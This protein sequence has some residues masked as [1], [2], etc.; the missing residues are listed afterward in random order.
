MNQNTNHDEHQEIDGPL[1][2]AVWAVVGEKI[3]ADA[4]ER[5]K[6]R[7]KEVTLGSRHGNNRDRSHRSFQPFLRPALAAAVVAVIVAAVILMSNPFGGSVVYAKAAE[8]LKNLESMVCKVQFSE[9]GLLDDEYEVFGEQQVTYLAPSLHRI[10]DRRHGTV[11]I[12]DRKLNRSVFLMSDAKQAIV[13]EGL[14]ATT[15]DA[16]SP[17]R[18]VEVLM[19]HVHVDRANN[20]DV[21]SIGTRTVDGAALRGYESIIDGETVRVWFDTETLLP[22]MIAVRLQIPSQMAGGNSVSIWQIMSDIKVDVDVSRDLFVTTVPGGYQTLSVDGNSTDRSPSTLN[23][24]VDMLRLCAGA[25]KSE[26]PAW[27]SMNDDSGTPL[28]IQDKFATALEQQVNEGSEQEK[29]SAIQSLQQFGATVGRA[30]AFQFSMKPENDWHYFGGAKL[31]DTSRPVLWYSPTADDKYKVIYADLSVKDVTRDNLPKQPEALA[32]QTFP[33][34]VIRVST[35]RFTLPKGTIRDYAEL[36]EIRK[37]GRQS[38]VTYLSLAWMPELME[39][40]V[41]H[42][43]GDE[44]KM[45]EV[46]PDWKPDRSSSGSRLAFL[47]EFTNLKGLDLMGLYLTQGD[48]D[49]IGSCQKL[50]R[51]SLYGVYV[52][53]DSSS[54]RII[55]DDLS[56]LSS[57]QSLELLDLSQSDFVGGL[58]HLANLRRLHALYLSSFEHLNDASVAELRVLPNLDTLVLAPVFSKNPR[59]TV[60]E[61]G[62]QS[63]T[64]LRRL[65]TLFVGE[66]GRWTLPVDRLQE[67][68][69]GVDVRSPTEGLHS[70]Q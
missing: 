44:L 19:R 1:E 69:P 50:R 54:R 41:Q 6:Q 63:L 11:Q 36:Q 22:S 30:M 48:L 55:G 31:N 2:T 13:V 56:H 4:V 8:R 68:L 7:A 10:E 14:A 12:V 18:L 24:V 34:K 35:P 37:R 29:A 42:Q 53:D 16:N 58:R 46:V 23:D 62:L 57:L 64:K 27:L 47:R 60:T 70:P 21:R 25:N 40:Q 5:V 67:L 17:A 52:F 61:S 51:L 66:H 20:E 3:D 45:Q 39:S 15:M 49:T 33:G 9:T 43:A 65:R 59:T 38:D 26:F 28:E 32:K